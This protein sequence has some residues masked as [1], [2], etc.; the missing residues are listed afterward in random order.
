MVGNCASTVE[1]KRKILESERHPWRKQ[2]KQV[3]V[4]TFACAQV[5]CYG[6]RC[7]QRQVIVENRVK[8]VSSFHSKTI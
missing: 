6:V 8:V 5:G 2:F 7:T 4:D 3:V 1:V